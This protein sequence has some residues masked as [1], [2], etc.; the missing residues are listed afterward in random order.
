MSLQQQQQQAIKYDYPQI[1]DTSTC[2]NTDETYIKAFLIN[3]EINR[4]FWKIPQDALKRYVD[5]F[6]GRPLVKH[7]SGDHPDYIKEAGLDERSPTFIKDMLRYQN[8]YKIGDIV[9]VQYES[10]KEDPNR[11]AYFAYIRLT[12]PGYLESV[13]G[14]SVSSYVSPL[15]FDLDFKKRG[16]PTTNFM[17]LHL[18]IVN[19]PAYGNIARIRASCNG[20]GQ[21][22]IDA[23]KKASIDTQQ[24]QEEVVEDENSYFVKSAATNQIYNMP[25]VQQQ[26]FNKQI[27][28]N[29]PGLTNLKQV[30]ENSGIDPNQLFTYD[31]ATGGYQPIT[32]SKTVKVK[33]TDAQGNLITET[34]DFRAGKQQQP[35][36]QYQQ[37]QQQQQEQENLQNS[38]LTNPLNTQEQQGLKVNTA[39]NQQP[40]ST[41]DQQSPNTNNSVSTAPQL[42]AEV[43]QRLKE[44]DIMKSEFDEI[45]KFKQTAEERQMLE[46][47]EAQR[48]TIDSAFMPL[49][50]DEGERQQVTDFF[51]SLNIEDSKL[52]DLLNFVINGTLNVS[53][54]PPQQK[55][56]NPATP[57]G[58]VPPQLQKAGIEEVIPVQA[59][60]RRKGGVKG[61]SLVMSSTNPSLLYNENGA[62]HNSSK[63]S[64]GILGDIDWKKFL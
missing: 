41:I 33:K 20:D 31:S 3:N 38:N 7:P 8:D 45:K 49:F 52:Q 47:S 27:D 43:L 48:Q 10:L 62:I 40:V 32:T 19:E 22:C 21:P 2:P 64:K 30:L 12:D 63:F 56:A 6:K 11:H 37:P 18:A 60:T 61:A 35:V 42:P 44:F 26:Q 17:P 15:I 53:D 29:Y 24:Q 36:Q 13:K 4:N 14:G 34:Q 39:L 58:K 54:N 1:T 51:V 28:P 25:T 5:G 55:T 9:D 50:P 59:Y 16:E 46:A 57:K 23:L